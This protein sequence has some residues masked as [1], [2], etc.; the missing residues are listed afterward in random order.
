V[1]D[2][3]AVCEGLKSGKIA[4]YGS[5]VFEFEPVT[6][7]C[8]LF[9]FENYVCTP[10]TAAESYEN[11]AMTGMKTAQALLDVFEGKEPENRLV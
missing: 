2:E 4:G 5:D 7:D 1:A 10:H 9:Q 3:E 6:R 11:Y 8:P